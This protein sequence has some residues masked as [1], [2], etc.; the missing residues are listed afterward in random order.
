MAVVFGIMVG[1]SFIIS[2]VVVARV[3][4][5]SHK[6]SWYDPIDDRKIHTGDVPRLG[7][8]GFASAFA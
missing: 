2:C 4:V 3:I 6:K 5:L 8:V 1:A 7:G